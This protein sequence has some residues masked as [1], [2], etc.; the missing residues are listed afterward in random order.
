MLWKANPSPQV[1]NV[2][3]SRT[4]AISIGGN[5]GKG[6]DFAKQIHV[7]IVGNREK[8]GRKGTWPPNPI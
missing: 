5:G 8:G 2:C 7:Q 3:E 1:E 4:A 6:K